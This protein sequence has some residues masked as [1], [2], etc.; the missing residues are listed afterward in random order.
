LAAVFQIE[1]LVNDACPFIDAGGFRPAGQ[2]DVRRIK[3]IRRRVLGKR[4][5]SRRIGVPVDALP[6]P[7]AIQS[8][9]NP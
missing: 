3:R 7:R 8:V 5:A 2:A 4:T 1:Q 9:N 6:D